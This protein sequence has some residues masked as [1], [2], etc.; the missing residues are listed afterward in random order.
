MEASVALSMCGNQADFLDRYRGNVAIN[1]KYRGDPKLSEKTLLALKKLDGATRDA[2]V[3]NA[4]EAIKDSWWASMQERSRELGLGDLWSDGRSGGWLVFKM[5]VNELEEKF[6]EVERR[7]KYCSLPFDQHV[8]AKCPFDSTSFTPEDPKNFDLF[9][10]FRAF[11]VEV[12][13]SLQHVGETFEDEVLFQ[14]EN[15]D[16][17]ASNGLPTGGSEANPAAFDEDSE[18]EGT[19]EGG[20]AR[21]A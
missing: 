5:T 17:Y 3:R 11:S 18:D 7:C 1:V 8:D 13:E 12:K 2:V 21:G 6:E 15:L 20:G 14:L 4:E 9:E 10:T 16:D 19:G